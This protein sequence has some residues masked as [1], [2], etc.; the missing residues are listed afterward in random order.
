MLYL[1]DPQRIW[2]FVA[3]NK[4]KDSDLLWTCLSK[5]IWETAGAS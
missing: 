3:G 2:V 5:R 4:P 1:E